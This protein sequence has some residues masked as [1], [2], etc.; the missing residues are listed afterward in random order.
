[1]A[2]DNR[3][4]NGSL[5]AY[6]CEPDRGSEPG[7]GWNIATR[8]T[9]YCKVNVITRANNQGPIEQCLRGS[10]YSDLKFTYVDPSRLLLKL[11]KLKIYLQQ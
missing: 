2:N 1:M 8:L 4:M 10:E 11:K 6:A 7:T 5:I 9:K 3:K